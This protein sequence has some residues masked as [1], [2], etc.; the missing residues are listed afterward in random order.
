MGKP[1]TEEHKRKISEAL[2]KLYGTQAE[3]GRSAEAQA[4]LERFTSEKVSYEEAKAERDSLRAQISKLGRKKSSRAAR[5]KLREQVKELTKRMKESRA[6]MIGIKSSASNDKAKKNAGVRIQKAEA[7]VGQYDALLSKVNDL[8]AKTTNPERRARLEARLER[9]KAGKH[10]Q[11]ERIREYKAIQANGKAKKKVSTF[12]FSEHLAEGTFKPFRALTLQEQR[13]DF[14]RLDEMLERQADQFESE[15]VDLSN[16]EIERVMS[17]MEKKVDVWDVAAIAGVAFLIRGAVKDSMRK[18][19]GTFYGIGTGL[20]MKELK[21][22]GRPETPSIDKRLMTLESSDLTD[23]YVDN[24]ENTTKS[25]ITS[26]IAAGAGTAGIVAA[27]RLKLQDEAAKTITNISGTITGEY[28]NR[29]H[30]SVLRRNAA[31]IVAYQRSEVLD[32]RTCPMCLSLDRRVVKPDDPMAS[33]HIV[34]THCRGLWVPVFSF[35]EEIPEVTGIPK[36][37]VDRFE[38]ID[39]RPVVNSFKNMKKPVNDVSKAAQEQIR[40]RF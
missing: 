24:L 30:A 33:L 15:M 7:K 9:A 17:S 39:G 37:I 27:T 13:I 6:K 21:L 22:P 4:H 36:S 35:D 8:I 31:K 11:Q 23:A 29:G 25:M 14:T 5:A 40:K 2:R 32:G 28:M 10:K 38:T 18:A 34:H 26:G 1:L 19:I 20:A 16:E 3:T 12:N